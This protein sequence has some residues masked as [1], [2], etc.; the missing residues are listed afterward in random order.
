MMAPQTAKVGPTLRF[1]PIRTRG[2]AISI[3]WPLLLGYALIRSA[4]LPMVTMLAPAA[5]AAIGAVR[6][7]QLGLSFQEGQT[8]VTRLLS[9]QRLPAEDVVAVRFG[10]PLLPGFPCSLRLDLRDGRSLKVGGVS[11]TKSVID[12]GQATP[13]RANRRVLDFLRMAGTAQP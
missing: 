13:D 8:V 6:C 1:G 7:W 3:S 11:T 12:V 4:G 10:D 9:V 5:I 2:I